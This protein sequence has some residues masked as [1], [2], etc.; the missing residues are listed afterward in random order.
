MPC[1][2]ERNNNATLRRQS[3]RKAAQVERPSARLQQ[4]SARRPLDRPTPTRSLPEPAGSRRSPRGPPGP[5]SDTAAGHDSSVGGGSLCADSR[6]E[7]VRNCARESVLSGG[8]RELKCQ[9]PL[10]IAAWAAQPEHLCNG[11]NTQAGVDAR[12]TH[13]RISCAKPQATSTQPL[14]DRAIEGRQYSSFSDPT[15]A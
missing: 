15:L 1:H 9:A 11:P 13:V 14:P 5:R 7:A 8:N 10:P 4:G 2:S 6:G 12:N 3:K